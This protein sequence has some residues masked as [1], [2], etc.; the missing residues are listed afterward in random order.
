MLKWANPDGSS[1]SGEFQYVCFEDDCPYYLDGW[2]WMQNQYNV[3]A[4]YR[5][6]LDPATGEQGPLPVWSPQA[7]KNDIIF[8]AEEANPDAR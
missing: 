1:W 5:C 2:T 3:A 7:L 6:R 4:S 8:D